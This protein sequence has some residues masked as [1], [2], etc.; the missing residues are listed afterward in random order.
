MTPEEQTPE[1]ETNPEETTNSEGDAPEPMTHEEILD[2]VGDQLGEVEIVTRD[3]EQ[4]K[5]W[6]AEFREPL[7]SLTTNALV[8]VIR[9][10]AEG[11]S[12]E[13]LRELYRS[14]SPRELNEV[15]SANAETFKRL[16]E[17]RQREAYLV[18]SAK[19]RLATTASSLMMSSLTKLP[20]LLV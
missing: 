11:R 14:L 20:F 4:A 3:I 5:E 19:A 1:A 15:V 13:Y 9:T 7:A 8:N 18:Q 16:A 17:V 2:F 10:H 6:L 12:E